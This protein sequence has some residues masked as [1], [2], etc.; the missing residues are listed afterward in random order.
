WWSDADKAYS[1]LV[2][3]KATPVESSTS[4]APAKMLYLGSDLRSRS[5]ENP[6]GQKVA[7]VHEVVVDPNIGRV[8][9]VVLAV[10]GE[11]AGTN[12]RMIAVPWE[13]LKSMPENTN[14]KID[15]LPL[16]TTREQLEKAPEFVVTTEVWKQA[17]E[18]GYV[19]G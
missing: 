17:S 8:A 10:G 1:K 14:Q 15:R 3:A 16:R 5:I 2:G 4:L 18:P 9:Y 7:T 6:E 12:E 19:I 13:A 11:S